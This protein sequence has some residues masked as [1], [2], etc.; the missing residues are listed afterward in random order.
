VV[1]SWHNATLGAAGGWAFEDLCGAFPSESLY[2]IFRAA[3]ERR[4]QSTR[5]FQKT[6]EAPPASMDA[7]QD[8]LHRRQARLLRPKIVHALREIRLRE[9]FDSPARL[10]WERY[11]RS[12]GALFGR[13][14]VE[15]L[16]PGGKY[17]WSG[18][19][20]PHQGSGLRDLLASGESLRRTWPRGLE[21]LSSMIIEGQKLMDEGVLSRLVLPWI[22]K[23]FIS[24]EREKDYE[25][26]PLLVRWIEGR[27]IRPLILLW[28]DTSHAQTPSLQLA[29]K[30]M[31]DAGCRCRGIG[32]FDGSGETRR[33]LAAEVI[34]KECREVDLFALRPFSDVHSG[35]SFHRMLE[36]FD[37]GRGRP[38]DS[39]WKDDLSFLYAGT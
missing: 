21:R 15:E 19:V 27:G 32:A 18:P 35:D 14:P 10:Q 39:S 7:L 28:D 31:K 34:L 17:S 20:S 25:Y 22:D 38:Y 29:L 16:S 6:R 12:A 13:F 11:L 2:D 5:L 33:E 9:I 3:V 24:S 8:L 26:L 1:L 4:L 23:F 30:R 36:Y 37:H